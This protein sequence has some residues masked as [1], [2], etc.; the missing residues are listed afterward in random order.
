MHPRDICGLKHPGNSESQGKSAGGGLPRQQEKDA[1]MN[2]GKFETFFLFSSPPSSFKLK[3]L[4]LVIY[5]I[6]RL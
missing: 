5:T 6:M 4:Y 3:H 2:K 1:V